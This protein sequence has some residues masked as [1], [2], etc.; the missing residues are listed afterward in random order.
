MLDVR[1]GSGH[2]KPDPYKTQDGKFIKLSPCTI[3]FY[4][5]RSGKSGAQTRRC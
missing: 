5:G 3:G 1:P 4:W 2:A